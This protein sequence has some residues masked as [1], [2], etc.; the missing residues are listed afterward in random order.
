MRL[1]KYTQDDGF[2]IA[3]NIDLVMSVSFH[4]NHPNSHNDAARLRFSFIGDKEGV[5]IIG[6]EAERVWNIVQG[7]TEYQTNER[8]ER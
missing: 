7:L 8:A 4:P 5:A 6:A 1:I 3:V 2:L